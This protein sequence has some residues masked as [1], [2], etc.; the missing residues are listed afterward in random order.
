VKPP[1][2]LRTC[3]IL[4]AIWLILTICAAQEPTHKVQISVQE[5]THIR[6]QKA[7]QT[8]WTDLGTK[9]GSFLVELPIADVTLELS[10]DFVFSASVSR[11]TVRMSEVWAQT[12]PEDFHDEPKWDRIAAVLLSG[13][14][15]LGALTRLI[16]KQTRAGTGTN[17]EPL[18]RPDGKVPKR[19]VGNY[20]LTGILGTGG[21]GVVYQG[22]DDDGH[23][24]AVKVPAPHLVCQ[25]DFHQRFLREIKL[26]LDLQHQRVV[27]VLEMPVGQEL[28]VVMEYVQ[29]T[30]LDKLPLQPWTIEWKLCLQWAAQTL[31][32]L[33]YIHSQGVIHRDL[34]PSNLMVLKD[35]SI[36]LMDFGIAHK[37]HGT[38]LTGTDS[39]MGTPVYMAPEQL[40]GAEIDPRADLFSLGLIL[41]ERLKP[42]L[43]YSDD[44]IET[45]RQKI[46]QPM[47]S[48]RES[49][50]SFPSAFDEF[51][52]TLLAM[53]PGGRFPDAS[54]ALS[55]LKPLLTLIKR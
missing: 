46:T 48:L 38:R 39:I 45:L 15:A 33:A 43:P 23:Q 47:T 34:K 31:E 52:M 37:I 7:G 49:N 8:T 18:I 30:P 26:G 54:T 12:H 21:M 2:L 53:Q 11:R 44:L 27:K 25:S 3:K 1:K 22:E 10:R 24:V 14:V 16:T 42:G 4:P 9:T 13:L 19:K 51:I 40:Q 50:P 35:N 36:K 20:R 32:A 28:Y 5:P 17:Q 41:Y 29:G 6:Y 55:S